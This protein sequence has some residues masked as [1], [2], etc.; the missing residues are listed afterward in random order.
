MVVSK[1]RA[2]AVAQELRR[3]GAGRIEI[4]AVG[5][6]QPV[7]AEARPAG[8]AGNRRVEIYLVN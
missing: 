5:D 7:F 2:D 8:E 3:Q 1:R 4:S 6:A